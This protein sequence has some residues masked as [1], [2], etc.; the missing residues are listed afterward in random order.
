[1]AFVGFLL[2]FGLGKLTIR[3]PFTARASGNQK[4]IRISTREFFS[5]ATFSGVFLPGQEVG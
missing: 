2:H 3:V 5:T 1:M 4:C